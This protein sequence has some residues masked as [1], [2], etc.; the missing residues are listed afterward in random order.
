MTGEELAVAVGLGV[1]GGQRGGGGAVNK[2]TLVT[3]G[4]ARLAPR[5]H[6]VISADARIVVG[7][8]TGRAEAIVMEVLAGSAPAREVTDG[9]GGQA[10]VVA[11][12]R[13][14]G[15]VVTFLHHAV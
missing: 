15:A 14:A 10:V 6:H 4:V 12:Q 9:Y 5:I 1:A 7:Q 2:A 11:R 8:V 13:V 3:R